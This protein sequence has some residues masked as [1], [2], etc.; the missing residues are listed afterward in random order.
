MLDQAGSAPHQQMYPPSTTRLLT[1]KKLLP[2]E[3][4]KTTAVATSPRLWR[5]YKP[6]AVV[7]CSKQFP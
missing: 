2:S 6:I 7:W 3:A 4:R 5:H 1:V